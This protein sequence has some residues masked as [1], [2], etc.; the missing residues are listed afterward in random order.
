MTFESKIEFLRN[1]GC[2]EVNHANQTLLEHLIGVYKLLKSWNVPEYIQDAGL[3]HSVYG[4]SYFKP[5]MLIDREV[6]KN[7]IG[8]PV[9]EYN[10]WNSETWWFPLQTGQLLMFPSSTVHQVDTKKGLNT[11][12]SLAF[13]T[14]YKGKLGTNNKLTELIL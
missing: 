11:R 5:V 4:T 14:F 6:V 3:F 2:D 13:N 1:L 10:I 12:T 8:I 9:K 7:I